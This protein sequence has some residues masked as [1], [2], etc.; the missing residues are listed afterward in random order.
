M[1][2]AAQSNTSCSPY[3]PQML[4]LS[5]FLALASFALEVACFWDL[6]GEYVDLDWYSD[7]SHSEMLNFSITPDQ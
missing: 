7:G 4:L 3:P 1:S 2:L 6:G 5:L